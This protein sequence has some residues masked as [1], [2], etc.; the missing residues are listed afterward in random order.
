MQEQL[1]E[2][3]QRIIPIAAHA[4]AGNLPDLESA[5]HRSLEGGL[6]INE[7]KEVLVQ[8]YAYCGFP[9]S[10]NALEVLMKLVTAR[11]QAGTV[12]QEGRAATP[13][14]VE[15]DSLACGSEN[16]TQLAG[17]PVAGALFDFAPAIDQFLKAHLFGDIFQR[18]ILDWQTREVATLSALAV[19]S[20]VEN[21]LRSHFTLSLN[22]GLT[23]ARLQHFIH[24]LEEA[25]GS[26]AAGR[27]GQVLNTLY[28]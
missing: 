13:P 20:G 15:W 10:L 5:I 18:D 25:C 17:Q 3:Q 11:R 28:K 7:I 23:H 9:R 21:Q 2:R 22:T 27:A 16:Q 26:A 8:L 1:N 6:T 19:M 4:A 12:D 14:P 24:I